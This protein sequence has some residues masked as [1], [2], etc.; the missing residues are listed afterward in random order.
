MQTVLIITVPVIGCQPLDLC[1]VLMV[2]METLG[3][4]HKAPYEKTELHV[5]SNTLALNYNKTKEHCKF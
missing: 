5:K 1:L 2:S 4:I 3:N